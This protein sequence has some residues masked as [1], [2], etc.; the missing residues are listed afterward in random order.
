MAEVKKIVI[1]VNKKELVL[2]PDEARSLR[3]VLNELIGSTTYFY[4]PIYPMPW[5][6]T[7]CRTDNTV[8]I[9]YNNG[10]VS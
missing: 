1:E 10:Q 5:V 2:T 6:Y 8:T 4:Q 3:D 9:S 7:T